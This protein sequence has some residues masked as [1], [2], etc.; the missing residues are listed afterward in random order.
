MQTSPNGMMCASCKD[1]SLHGVRTTSVA[2]ASSFGFEFTGTGGEYFRI[3]IV[4]MLLTILTL[5]IYSAWAKVR[6]NRYFYRNTKLAG[7]S[8]DYHGNPIAI[9][10]GRILAA[11][12][13][14]AYYFSKQFS[15]T[16]YIAVVVLV[17]A[18][19][20]WML[21]RAYAFRL[22]NTSWRGI[23]LR[24]HGGV[25]SAY[26]VFVLYGCLTILTLGLC[27][28]LFYRQIR[29]FMVNNAAFGT[30]RSELNISAGQVYT[31][32]LK[33]LLIAFA[34]GIVLS[35]AMSLLAGYMGS[36]VFANR[37][38]ISP[39]MIAW[40]IIILMTVY[41]L[42]R[43]IVISFFRTRM[44][45]LIWDNSRLGSIR[46]D[47]YQRAR[48]LASIIAANALLTFLT[49]GF[50]WPWAKVQLAR[51]YA[52]TLLVSAPEGLNN[53]VADTEAAV[54]AA[55]DEISGALDV[56]FSF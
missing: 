1:G 55:G 24:F 10:K 13:I 8:F 3:W 38:Q 5:G 43:V 45:N 6:K 21:T 54:S 26:V 53:F 20:P 17:A 9:L 31:V 52:D 29:M 50:Y 44:T 4:N 39:A 46:F 14:A 35:I 41:M 47:S 51:Y 16:L 23:R 11:L 34:I 42:Y 2:D 18:I 25:A 49:L 27:Y 15:P 22:Y 36:L 40:I 19:I 37:R 7:S 30:T 33:T 48:D 32:F 56:D 12:I 28:P